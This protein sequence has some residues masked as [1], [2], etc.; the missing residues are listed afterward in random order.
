[1]MKETEI[2]KILQEVE[3]GYDTM[4]NKFSQTRKY[5]W[6]GL[7]FIADYVKNE[8][9]VLDF[10]CGNGRLLE[11]FFDK[12]VDYTGVDISRKLIDIAKKKYPDRADNFQK[13]SSSESLPFPD[14]SFNA[15]YSI[16]V[17]HHLPSEELR[18][19]IAK[20]LF[21]VLQ[22]E[23]RIVITVWNLWLASRRQAVGSAS[24]G[25]QKKYIKNIFQ[26]WKNKILGKS[27]LDWNDCH[28]SFSDNAGNK[29]QRFHHAFTR[30]ELKKLFSNAGFKV[31]K[32]EVI[33]ARNIL[34][35]AKKKG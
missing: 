30:R 15:V 19:K 20:E 22:P 5:F 4:A 2:N 14:N 26:N 18:H 6:R 11:L 13:I 3:D 7:E 27:E 1:M 17:F 24:R 33:N 25:G 29:F 16:A 35:V 9:K 10:G 8:D 32:C 34:L 31:E 21:R 28:I 23:G 12:N